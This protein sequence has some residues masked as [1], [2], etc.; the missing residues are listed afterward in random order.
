MPNCCWIAS[1]GAC[2]VLFALYFGAVAGA[3]RWSCEVLPPSA[4]RAPPGSSFSMA[5]TID[6]E[7]ECEL[8][9]ERLLLSD[10]PGPRGA[11]RRVNL[12]DVYF[13]RPP[14]ELGRRPLY[15]QEHI[16]D[17]FRCGPARIV[18]SSSAARS[19]LQ[20]LF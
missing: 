11:F 2:L 10:V 6:Y 19:S 7:D 1:G 16:P 13:R 20:R 14:W 9:Y 3:R 18:D 12:E 5:R 4:P 15:S 8:N 17:D